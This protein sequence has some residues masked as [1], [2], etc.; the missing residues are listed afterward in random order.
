MTSRRWGLPREW[1]VF[2]VIVVDLIGF[3]IV[4]PILPFMSP[5]LG[6]DEFDVALVIAL[7]SLCAGLAGPYWGAL[8]DRIGR[9]KVLIICLT[10]GAVSYV[11]LGF[12]HQ[13]WLVYAARA[14]AGV[15]AGN[16]PV[17]S[18]LMADLSRP[19][20]R[21]K[22]MGLV[23]TAF[24]LGLILGP[25]LGG[26]LAG[27]GESFAAA[28]FF[29]ASMSLLSV[30]LAIFLLPNDQPS[31]SITR[32]A[33][34]KSSPAEFARETRSELLLIQYVLH[35]FAVG[36]AIYLSPLWLATLLGWGPREI[37]ILF[38]LVGVGMITIQ[39]VL[40]NWLTTRFGLINVLS[41]GAVIFAVSL[42]A[43][44]WMTGEY[45]RAFAVFAAFTG[46]T[47]ILPVLNTVA[48]IIVPDGERGRMMGLT[49]FAAS[50]GR[51]MGPL[52]VGLVLAIG[53]Y[54]FAWLMLALPVIFVLFWSLTRARRYQ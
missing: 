48:S 50:I 18:A 37:G 22:A 47:C 32:S 31:R 3:G 35:T 36:A 11:I 42:I 53:G 21:A 54:T 8:S 26:L 34:V 6:G 23:G 41:A 40:L 5:A 39:G 17:A 20:R 2:S 52:I 27:D 28:G 46:A 44:P 16:L 13:L 4:I 51:V 12:A 25:L 1:L 29:A 43:A 15:M 45:P 24:G 49:A 7:Y 33:K 9:K 10:G 30:V 19:E 38:G 14:L